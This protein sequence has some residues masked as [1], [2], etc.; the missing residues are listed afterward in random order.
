MDTAAQP[1][2]EHRTI[3]VDFRDE[4]TDCRLSADSKAFV[5]CVLA[6]RLALDFQL[7]H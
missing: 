1:R 5:A 6:F 7:K 2:R 4:A 3:T